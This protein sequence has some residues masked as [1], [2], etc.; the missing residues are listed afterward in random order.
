VAKKSTS[1]GKKSAV[2]RIEGARQHNLKSLNLDIAHNT[3][4]VITGP[5]GSGKSS[6]AFHT[7]YAEG[8]RRY[9]ETFSPYI[10]QFFDRMDKPDVDLIDGILPAIAIEQKNHV[11]TTR[12]TVGTLTEIND[13]LKVLFGRA[14][15]GY[16]PQTGEEIQ[17]D[18]PES[19]LAWLFEHR[20]EQSMLVLFRVRVP[21]KATPEDFFPLLNQQGFLRVLLYGKMFRT[22]EP[23]E[24]NYKSLPA[25]MWI[26][27]D[28]IQIKAR[29]RSRV[30]EALEAAARHGKGTF[31]TVSA[32]EPS[33]TMKE[34]TND[35]VNPATGFKLCEPSAGLFSFNSPRGACVK[36]RGFGRVIGIDLAKA[37]PDPTLSIR[38][39]AIKP[40]LGERGEECQRDLLRCC[41]TQGLNVNTPWEDLSADEQD[42]VKYGEGGDPESNWREAQWYGI[43]G[44]FDWLESKAYKMHVRVFLSRYRS[45]TECPDCR[46]KRLRPEA[47]CFRVEGKTLP[48]IWNTPVCDLAPWF[49]GLPAHEP[50]LEL[51]RKEIHSRLQ[52]L[53]DVGLG[54]LTLDRQT[55]TL[56]G[57]EMERVNLTTC[58][59]AALT[60]TLFVLDEPTV[61]LHARDIHRLVGVMKGLRDKGNTIVVVEHEEAVMTAADEIID[62]G[63][64]AGDG[65]GTLV[66]QGPAVNPKQKTGT[67]PWLDGRMS[68]PLPT[69]RRKPSKKQITIQGATRH[70]LKKLDLTLPLGL[71][72][73]L[74]GVSGSGK[75]TLAHDVLYLNLAKKL[76]REISDDGEP[77]LIK[78]ISG[79][80]HVQEVLLVDQSS[81]ARTPRSTPAVF[82]GAFDVIRQLMTETDQAKASS[83]QPGYFSFNS[84]EGR[85]D[86]CAGAG[87]ERV[88]MQFL[89]DIQVTCPDCNGKRYRLSA[90][91]FLLEKKN[92]SEILEL[93]VS[94][95]IE[96]FR[97]IANQK[98]QTK[99]NASLANKVCDLLHP[100]ARVGLGYLR[101][102]QPLN[103]LSGGESQRLK[104]CQLLD[105][106]AHQN[107]LLIL[108]E[109]TT[110]LHFSDIATLLDVFQ[111]L[112]EAGNSLL[113]IEHQLDVMA[114]ADWLIDL[115]PGAGADGGRIIGTGTPETIAAT[116]SE[117]ALYLRSKLGLPGSPVT[118]VTR[119]SKPA[120]LPNE[121][122]LHGARHHNLK[123]VSLAIPRDQFVVIS[124]LS[125][126]GKSTLAFDI[127]F[128]EGQRRFLD[129]MSAYARQFADQLEKP[130]IDHLSGLPPTVAIEQRISQ[131]GGKSTVATITEVWNFI[132]L[133]YAKL[134]IRY[135]CGKPVE[136]QSLSS[137]EQSIRSTLSKGP[138]KLF[139]P[140]IRGRKGYHNEVAE[141]ALKHGYTMML[142]DKRLIPAK[143]FQ[144]LE[145]FKEHDVDVMIFEFSSA[146]DPIGAKLEEALKIGK[147]SVRI[148]TAEKKFHILSS[149]QSCATCGT[150]YE[151]LD[152]RHF[153]FN[154]PHGWC[155]DCR[156]YGLVPRKRHALDL[157]R[158]DS[159]LAA[160]VDEERSLERMDPE[161]LITCP[162]C[163]G[164]RLH[165]HSRQ[166]QV[167]DVAIEAIAQRSIQD[168]AE[169]FSALKFPEKRQQMIARDIIPEIHQRLQFLSKVGLGYLQLSRSARTLSGGE[170]QRIRLAAQLGSNLRGV[171]YVLDEPTIGLHPRD[172]AALLDTLVSLRDRG[173]SLVVVEHDEDTIARADWLIDLGPAAGRLGGQIVYE[174]KPPRLGQ[175]HSAKSTEHS[176]TLRA[177]SMEINHPSRGKRRPVDKKQAFLSLSGCSVNNLKQVSVSIPIG[178]LTVL[179]GVSGSGKSSLMHGCLS[180]A[181]RNDKPNK[182]GHA[183][184]T[185]ALNMDRIDAVYEVDQSPIGKTSRSCPATYVGIFDE[186]RKVFAQL[187]EAR[188]RGFEATRFSFNTEGGRCEECKGNGRIK[189]EMDFLPSAWIPC[190][191][192]Q[193]KRYNSA[194]LEVTY[195]DQSIADVLAMPIEE[196]ARFFETH[197][198]LA[199][200]LRLLNETGLGYL[201]LGQA[202]PTLSG[203]EAQRIKLISEIAR[204]RSLRKRMANLNNAK[205]NLYLIEEPTVGLHLEDVR[206]LIDVLHRMVDEGHTVVVI[207]H[208]MAVAAEADWIIDVG[209]EAGADGG[210]I[211]AQGPPELIARSKTSRTAPFLAELL[212]HSPD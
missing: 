164:A 87:F 129:S 159:L 39:G 182:K 168:A 65:G 35:W 64:L 178:C 82:C 94:A 29:S 155:T 106:K 191:I 179:T 122:S 136:K 23:A 25:E 60:N 123:N 194:T 124:G 22:D 37:V 177:M 130:D 121:I 111:Q 134:G 188:A 128:A 135:C 186:I 151:D 184:Y 51:V 24:C 195:K 140:L 112:V 133:L 61:G 62:I 9:V 127:L 18:S 167:A 41:K 43:K 45:Y 81:L 34:F 19:A 28:R 3:L 4:T 46:G 8:Q 161:D 2:I 98:N 196:A 202:S 70:N 5:S 11:R 181:A 79:S 12:S 166:V 1:T 69:K 117:T 44:F 153:S 67:I 139:A 171:L 48:E 141:W 204:G 138:V 210:E 125:G 131:G 107:K 83:L 160:E 154:S 42:W 110:G 58:L 16:D 145:R 36:C 192:C 17:P 77:A 212:K 146:K 190:E 53:N 86:R 197:S 211:V 142:A 38:G 10:R 26:V 144:R 7:L 198:R 71:F 49:A 113:V 189:L 200:P 207:E 75:S 132:R 14:A 40:F 163:D 99:K 31:A 209:P 50:S 206:R 152:P 97:S 6:L 170:S 116:D 20:N 104:L 100:L 73:C 208:H 101:L 174:G 21:E 173:N 13:Y 162:T 137:M 56:S 105:P 169:H 201:T 172:N 120:I 15:K 108:D 157:S 89:S 109:P 119:L 205:G 63:P 102:G 147:G 88:E 33:G 30:L 148:L 95:A 118:K 59:G 126:S 156:G 165:L 114:A 103:T 84:G 57:G 199:E 158:F 74:S 115:G 193:G 72:V 180:P 47:L 183:G 54:Y 85:C 175:K 149:S 176:P 80:E 203:G 27:Q 150:S 32:D 78:S 55:R 68:I 93:S 187:P 185:K 91:E 143:N 52:Y 76:G 66:Y 90:L 96:F 92:I